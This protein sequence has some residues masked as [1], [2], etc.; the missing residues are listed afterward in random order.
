MR[1]RSPVRRSPAQGC[2]GCG[3]MLRMTRRSDAPSLWNKTPWLTLA[4][5]PVVNSPNPEE[6]RSEATSKNTKK[7]VLRVSGC[8]QEGYRSWM[9]G[10]REVGRSQRETEVEEEGRS[11]EEKEGGR[12]WWRGS[13]Y[14]IFFILS[15][16]SARRWWTR[17]QSCHS[18]SRWCCRGEGRGASLIPGLD[19]IF[20]RVDAFLAH[21]PNLFCNTHTT[22]YHAFELWRS[23]VST[24]IRSEA[25]LTGLSSSSIKAL[26]E[27][28]LIFV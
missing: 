11:S 19:P 25:K 23:A 15:S 16:A 17:V 13:L 7:R 3:W 6:F 9:D 18:R 22:F 4:R 5:P 24:H 12:D 28:I 20:P 10:G 8:K 26:S 14:L 27:E 1:V 2:W 21:L